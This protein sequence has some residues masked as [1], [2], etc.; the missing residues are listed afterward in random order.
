MS[1]V[2]DLL[3]DGASAVQCVTGL[4]SDAY[5]GLRV[6]GALEKRDP[7]DSLQ[8]SEAHPSPADAG[9][10][11]V[12]EL[13][14][15]LTETPAISISTLRKTLDVNEPEFADTLAA[16]VANGLVSVRSKTSNDALV[17]LTPIGRLTLGD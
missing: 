12:K 10:F 16:S 1:H 15:L 6:R 9:Q 4:F 5:L 13:L 2:Q 3:E 11:H 14:D 7:R 8:S 17:E